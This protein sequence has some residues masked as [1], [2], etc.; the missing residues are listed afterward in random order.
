[1]NLLKSRGSFCIILNTMTSNES[2]ILG[3]KTSLW[4]LVIYIRQAYNSKHCLICFTFIHEFFIVLCCTVYFFILYGSWFIIGH[5]G[6]NIF[7]SYC[8]GWFHFCINW[9]NI[10]VLNY[11][12]SF[13]HF[14]GPDTSFAAIY[15]T[16]SWVEPKIAHPNTCYF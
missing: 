1:M 6:D 8:F 14:K 11:F 13:G 5:F 16:S 12:D 4:G 9:I 2:I 7:K 15:V 3:T 10:A